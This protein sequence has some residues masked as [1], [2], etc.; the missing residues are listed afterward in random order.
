MIQLAQLRLL[1]QHLSFVILLYGGRAGIRLGSA[2]PCF[3][4]PYVVTCGGHCYL[5]GL[6]GFIGFGLNPEYFWGYPG[7]RAVLYF[8]LFV[9]L[10]SLLGKAWCGWICPFGLVQDWLTMLRNRLRI[11]ESRLSPQ[12]EKRLA[13]IRYILLVYLCVM[14]VLITA[15]LVHPDF[16]LPFCNICPGK[17]LL[18]LFAGETRHLALVLDNGV[19]LGQSALLLV[20][21]GGML[22]GMFFSRRFFCRFCPLLALIHLLKP[23]TLFRLVKEPR[24]CIGC[25]TCRRACDMGVQEVYLEK[26]RADVQTGACTDCGA[27]ADVCPSRKVLSLRFAGIP[28]FSSSAENACGLKNKVTHRK[29]HE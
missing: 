3:A 26:E 15:E 13:P 16:C 24:G 19:L 10:V 28:L 7:L 22:V 17:S 5:M 11:R 6:Q 29:A 12:W 25:G 27:C 14:P 18:P 21:T 8:L 20:I 23:L 9:L 1:V 2:L 4:C